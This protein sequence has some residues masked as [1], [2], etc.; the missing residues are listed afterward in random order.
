MDGTAVGC[1]LVVLEAKAE[2]VVQILS[3]AV[4]LVI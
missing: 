1:L 4:D 3:A 2:L